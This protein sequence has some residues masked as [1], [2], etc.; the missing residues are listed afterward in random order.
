QYYLP[1]GFRTTIRLT[2]DLR[3]LTYL[4]ELRATRFVHPTLRMRAVEMA[5]VLEEECG[6][7]GLVLHLDGEPDRFDVRRGEH[8]IVT[9]E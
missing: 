8:D 7:Y 4:V 1:M 5:N 6:Q 2:G 9:K 3:A